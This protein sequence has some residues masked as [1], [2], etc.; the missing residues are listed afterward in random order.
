MSLANNCSDFGSRRKSYRFEKRCKEFI[1]GKGAFLLS[2]V[3]T[4][5]IL[6]FNGKRHQFFK[7]IWIFISLRVW[8]FNTHGNQIKKKSERLP[9]DES[10][11]A[12]HR[13]VYRINLLKNAKFI[14]NI[15]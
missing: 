5:R 3:T 8:I 1:C 12:D 4:S 9:G 13:S 10:L 14:L 7:K 2:E 15:Q 6:N 11:L